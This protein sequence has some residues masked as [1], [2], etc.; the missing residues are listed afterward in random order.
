MKAKINNRTATTK[1][2]GAQLD[3][4]VGLWL[5]FSPTLRSPHRA[6]THPFSFHLIWYIM[7]NNNN[8]NNLKIYRTRRSISISWT[9][10]GVPTHV[11]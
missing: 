6:T 3:E 8:N 9:R 4:F 5:S 2:I 11:K 10:N 1:Y 7:N